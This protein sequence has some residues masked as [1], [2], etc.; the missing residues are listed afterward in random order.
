MKFDKDGF[1]KP[2]NLTITYDIYYR[3]EDD[4][5]SGNFPIDVIVN[6]PD[7]WNL[8]PLSLNHLLPCIFKVEQGK[9]VRGMPTTSIQ[10]YG[11]LN[12]KVLDDSDR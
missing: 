12:K 6:F 1:S 3:N 9:E 11:S 2:E 10:V 8:K 4:L 7:S 5:K